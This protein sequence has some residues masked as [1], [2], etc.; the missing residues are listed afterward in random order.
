MD[1]TLQKYQKWT[2]WLIAGLLVFRVVCL[3]ISPLGLHGDEAQYW[4]WS[5]DLDWGYFTKPPLIA[6]TIWVT[7]SIFGDAEWAVRISSPVLH[8]ITAFV[9]FRTAKLAF[10]AKTGFWAAAIY[11]LMPALWL[12]SG[13]VSTDVPLLLCWALAMNAWLHLR[14][15][16]IWPRALQL[17]VAVGFGLLAKYAMLFFLPALGLA[18]L[19]D[20]PTRKGLNTFK[21]YAAGFITFLIFLPNILWNFAHDFATVTH[22]ADNANMGE[23][24]PF[25]PMELL[26]F[27]GDQLAVF[28]PV[29]L[30]LFVLALI[31]ALRGKLDRPALWIALF[32]LSPLLIISLQALLSRANANWAVTSYVA[33]SI[34]TA[35]YAVKFWPKLKLWLMGGIGFQSVLCLI[36]ALIMMSSSLTDAAGLTNSAKRLRKWPETVKIVEA[37]Y[38]QGHE[39]RAYETLALD[40]RIIFYDLNYYGLAEKLPMK[41]WMHEAAPANHAELTYPLPAQEGPVLV[42]NY[43]DHY[44]DELREDF[45]RL[46]RLPDVDIDLGGGKRRKLRVWAGYG[47]VPT[48][49]RER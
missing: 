49:G 26:T 13:I 32:A 22:T 24:I 27:W 35:H 33:G 2:L 34:L 6:W 5:K 9:I 18:F 11:L 20:K 43:Y 21:G 30:V 3:L 23:S 14:E 16:A 36:L 42:L 31:A 12:S 44:E 48:T 40:K 45:A 1:I 17:G 4:A 41:M 46:E 47:Y 8:S 25:H 39:G 15:K 19:F 37:I 29:T 28:G 38:A 7:T 10:D